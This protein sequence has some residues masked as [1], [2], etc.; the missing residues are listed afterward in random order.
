MQV[1]YHRF[2]QKK[3]RKVIDYVGL[4]ETSSLSIRRVESHWGNVFLFFQ[5]FSNLHFFISMCKIKIYQNNLNIILMFAIKS[6]PK[7]GARKK[8]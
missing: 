7:F 1:L 5:V 2:F 8:I 3:L 6:F 4:R